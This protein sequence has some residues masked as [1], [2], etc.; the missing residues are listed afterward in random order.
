MSELTFTTRLEIYFRRLVECFTLPSA[1]SLKGPR[2]LPTLC[3]SIGC[4]GEAAFEFPL[5]LIGDFITYVA[6]RTRIIRMHVKRLSNL[7]GIS[8]HTW[9]SGKRS[10]FKSP[11]PRISVKNYWK[12]DARHLS[13][14]NNLSPMKPSSSII[15]RLEN[16]LPGRHVRATQRLKLEILRLDTQ[17]SND[18]HLSSPPSTALEYH[19]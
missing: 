19:R 8:L 3:S 1:R 4:I 9:R 13:T 14:R 17:K 18:N 12:S 11:T 2:N 16:S 5:R 10:S 7:S 6:K 15:I